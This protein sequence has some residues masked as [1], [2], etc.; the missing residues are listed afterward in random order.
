MV[1]KS[2]EPA[3]VSDL[4]RRIYA[5]A[6]KIPRGKVAT[7]GQVAELAGIPRGARVAGA[8]MRALKSGAAT[9]AVPWHRVVGKRGPSA[10][11]ISIQDPV[12]GAIQ[13]QLLERE[14]VVFRPS[15]VIALAQFGWLPDD[16]RA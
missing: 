9:S 10:A 5:V 13:R 14:G 4:Y 15:G 8:A 2:K 6:L 7:Y 1:S 3:G 12:G 11:R 16:F